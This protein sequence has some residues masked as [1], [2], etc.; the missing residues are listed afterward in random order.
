M[1][2]AWSDSPIQQPNPP[3]QTPPGVLALTIA[4]ILPPSLL[5]PTPFSWRLRGTTTPF[6]FF[7]LLVSATTLNFG[8]TTGSGLP[9]LLRDTTPNKALCDMSR[10]ENTGK[11]LDTIFDLLTETQNTLL[12]AS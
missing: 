8:L 9:T 3:A 4:T 7:F 1:K 6:Y 12:I 5:S 2:L 11:C 10:D